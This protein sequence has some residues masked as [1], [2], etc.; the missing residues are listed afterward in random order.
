MC[1]PCPKGFW[2][3]GEYMPPIECTSRS[4]T[5]V[6]GT[7]KPVDCLCQGRT[8]GIDCQPCANKDLCLLLG[9]NQMPFI[10]AIEIR[11]SGP[12]DSDRI[13]NETCLQWGTT[14][15]YTLPWTIAQARV[16]KNGKVWSWMIVVEAMPLFEN[17]ANIVKN[18]T[19]CML[20]NGFDVSLSSVFSRFS[21]TS[22]VQKAVPCGLNFEWSGD[23]SGQ[24][25]S[26]ISGHE[27]NITLGEV[28]CSPCAMGTIRKSRTQ[29][30]CL[31]C[32]DNNS[33]APWL[34]MEHCV[35]KEGYYMDHSLHLCTS[36]K[37]GIEGYAI[38][39]SIFFVIPLTIV[40]WI[41][42]ITIVCLISTLC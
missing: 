40:V 30:G 6:V 28:W 8:H 5:T 26:C 21:V 14:I 16:G 9:S 23:A 10:S 33:H 15:V 27:R 32:Q 12:I 22:S 4:T 19:T 39:S 36:K 18:I 34:G 35:C 24:Q 1:I 42:S 3:Y 7:H 13:L 29:Q 37:M 25:C 20:D 2:C 11:G 41:L 38:L 17:E 31:P